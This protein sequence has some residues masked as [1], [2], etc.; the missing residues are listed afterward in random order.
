MKS[1]SHFPRD[2]DKSSFVEDPQGVVRLV[3]CAQPF[4]LLLFVMFSL[5]AIRFDYETVLMFS[6]CKNCRCLGQKILTILFSFS[7]V[8]F[9]QDDSICFRFKNIDF[10]QD[11]LNKL[12]ILSQ[13]FHS[14]HPKSS[15]CREMYS[16][17]ESLSKYVFSNM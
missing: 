1:R 12:E 9:F 16:G 3:L 5:R 15:K 2:T 10:S 14:Q 11:V 8:S 17:I 6:R 7:F 13:S 4:S